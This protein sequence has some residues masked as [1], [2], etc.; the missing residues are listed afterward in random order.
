VKAEEMSDYGRLVYKLAV[1]HEVFEMKDL[2]TL[3][4]ETTEFSVGDATLYMYL[5]GQRTP[6][7]GFSDQV[8]RALE[9]DD[10]MYHLLLYVYD[11]TTGRLSPAQRE[12]TSRFERVLMEDARGRYLKNGEGAAN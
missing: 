4:R 12:Q 7:P 6:P 9:L 1:I 3:L 2:G 11:K 8:R 5:K 10:D